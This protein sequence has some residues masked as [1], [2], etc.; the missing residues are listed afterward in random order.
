M[1]YAL[2]VGKPKPVPEAPPAAVLPQ[3]DVVV[4]QPEERSLAVH[5]QGTVRPL[6]EI[7]L[8][9]RVS[10]RVEQVSPRFAEGG[11]FAADEALVKVEDVDYTLAIARA[12]SQVAAARQSLAEERGRALQARREWR[13]L[14]SEDA[15][16]LFL[17]EPQIAAAEAAL[18]SAQADL[19]AARLDFERTEISAP[20]SGRVSE[21]LVDVGQF[22]S[23]GT[24]VATVYGTDAVQV[25]LPL[26]GRQVALLDLPLS[27]EGGATEG[28]AGAPVQLRAVFAN[29]EWEWQ[30]HIVRTDAS[31]DENSRLVYAVAE[32]EK[33]FAR[34][35]GSERPPLSPGLFVDATIRGQPLPNVTPLPRS[36]LRSDETVIVVDGGKVTHPRPVHILDSEGGTVW[37][38]GLE[39][40]ERVVVREPVR[41]VAGMAVRVNTLADLAVG[42]GALDAGDLVR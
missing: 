13:D 41:L 4:A 33:P 20:F 18:K 11:F 16:A 42:A 10:G 1:A 7:K 28:Q 22:V 24:A 35:S 19:T 2:L 29:R 34:D 37:V 6:R 40:G 23:P 3:V 39:P 15:N 32:V 5:T 30:G 21:K 9:S 25:R 26:T 12:E 14:G 38:Q 31:I 8:V 27:Y 17:R 36:A